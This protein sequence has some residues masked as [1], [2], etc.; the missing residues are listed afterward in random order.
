MLRQIFRRK[1]EAII[2]CNLGTLERILKSFSI[3]F[4]LSLLV[5]FQV[6][7]YFFISEGFFF[8]LPRMWKC[9]ACNCVMYGCASV[10]SAYSTPL[11]PFLVTETFL[12]LENCPAQLQGSC[13]S[14]TGVGKWSSGP[15]GFFLGGGYWHKSRT[16]NDLMPFEVLSGKFQGSPFIIMWQNLLSIKPPEERQN[17]EIKI[18]VETITSLD[19]PP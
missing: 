7:M 3:F 10:L 5:I 9:L 1:E 8:F 2:S 15:I 16:K 12:P 13:F 14:A 19:P 18:S 11:L 17:R 4:F 6:V